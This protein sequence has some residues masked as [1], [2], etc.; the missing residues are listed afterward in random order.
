MHFT[1]LPT[2]VYG[3]VLFAAAIAYTILQ[4]AI[5][6]HEGNQSVLA[7]AI[8]GDTKGKMSLLLY[9]LGIPLAF[10]HPLI[11]DAI[12]AAVAFIWLVPDKCIEARL[13]VHG[14]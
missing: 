3:A 2:A 5:I 4:N 9:L 6:A 1:A 14:K 7:T 12:Y 10:V 11:S 13:A 8:G